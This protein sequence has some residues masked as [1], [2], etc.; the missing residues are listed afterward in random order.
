MTAETA[1]VATTSADL[2]FEFR[3][4]WNYSLLPRHWLLG[5]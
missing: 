3:G 4:E 1:D 5:D 2:P